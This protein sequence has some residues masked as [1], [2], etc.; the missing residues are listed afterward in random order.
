LLREQASELLN[1]PYPSTLKGKRDRAILALLIGCGLRRAELLS[2]EIDQIQ[3]REGRWV[4]P[5]LLGKGIH[6]L[7]ARRGE[8][9][10][11]GVDRGRRSF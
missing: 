2:L 3:Q 1:A 4:I 10:G 7:G 11:G 5:D 6:G 9:A 8:S